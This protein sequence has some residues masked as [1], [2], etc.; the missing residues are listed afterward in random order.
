M[1]TRV[2][3][4]DRTVRRAFLEHYG[5]TPNDYLKARRFNLVY[6]ELLRSDPT[7]ARVNTIADRWGF[8]HMGQLAAGYRDQFGEIPSETLARVR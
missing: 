5:V 4:G 7:H 2:G 3:V 6:R 1:S 8:S